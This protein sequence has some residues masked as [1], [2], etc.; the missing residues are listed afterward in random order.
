MSWQICLIR[1][2]GKPDAQRGNTLGRVNEYVE[3]T[4]PCLLAAASCTAHTA[5]TVRWNILRHKPYDANQLVLWDLTGLPAFLG[6]AVFA[7]ECAP[8]A[9]N[10]YSSLGVVEVRGSR[11]ASP[12]AMMTQH[13]IAGQKCF[14]S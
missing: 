1:C 14:S 13:P 4:G 7:F 2:Y 3:I 10:I 11:P 5:R 8:T 12:Y 6:P 9:L